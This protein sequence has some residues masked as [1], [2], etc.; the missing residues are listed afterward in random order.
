MEGKR[1]CQVPA[2]HPRTWRP[3]LEAA[4]LPE[5]SLSWFGSG[6]PRL[7]LTRCNDSHGS[8]RSAHSSWSPQRPAREA[9]GP[10]PTPSSRGMFLGPPSPGAT[11]PQVF[12]APGEGTI[13]YS[14]QGTF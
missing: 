12:Q 6:S 14:F 10:K 8:R 2:P 9:A 7:S 3:W 13:L 5:P 1:P 11:L 4:L